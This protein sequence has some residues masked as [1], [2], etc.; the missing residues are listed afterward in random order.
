MTHRAWTIDGAGGEPIHGNVH[1][2]SASGGATVRAVVLLAHGFKGYKDYGMFPRIAGALAEAGYAAHRFNFSHSGM[3]N[4]TDTFARPDLFELDT[5][6]KQVGDLTAVMDA[7]RAGNLGEE[8][9]RRPLVLFGHSRGGVTCLLTAG[10]LAADGGLESRGI[11]G[12][13]T[14]AA[15]ARAQG[16]P[17]DDARRL[18][19]DGF[20][21]SPSARTGQI[22]RIGRAWLDE[23]DEEPAAH[24][25]LALVAGIPRPL[26]VV[27]GG[28]DPTVPAESAERIGRAAQQARVE[29][30]DGAN[31][32]FDAPNPLPDDEPSSPAL[33]RLI[34]LLIAFAD[35]VS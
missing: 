25:L 15:P 3:T 32:V 14:A 4:D 1:L 12:I 26:L 33:A 10:R 13:A 11:R 30:I 27:H 29:I 16:L 22:L 18:R 21:E 7:A 9:A 28:A 19:D 34:A 6:N 24:D 5:W 2:P 17:D 31:H 8:S 35:E 20:L 23:Q